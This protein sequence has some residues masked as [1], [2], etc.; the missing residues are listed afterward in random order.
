MPLQ[1][2][3]MQKNLVISQTKVEKYFLSL[4]DNE[5]SGLRELVS[6]DTLVV[7]LLSRIVVTLHV[8]RKWL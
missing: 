6:Q 7:A 4:S 3:H 5:I 8:A 1:D 2:R